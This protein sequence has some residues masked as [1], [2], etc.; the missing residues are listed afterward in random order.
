MPKE[1]LTGKAVRI[2][3][4][5]DDELM[6]PS[7]KR[8]ALSSGEPSSKP[9]EVA[10]TEDVLRKLLADQ[11]QQFL[12]AQSAALAE[13]ISGLEK[14][15]D[16]RMSGIEGK[17][18][19]HEERFRDLEK[20]LA[21]GLEASRSETSSTRAGSDSSDMEFRRKTTLVLGG[22]QRDTRRSVILSDVSSF[23]GKLGI[24]SSLVDN[25]AFTTGPRRNTA[26]L[27]FKIR[28]GEGLT[29]VRQRMLKVIQMTAK[30]EL[31]VSSSG[32]K[33]FAT[34][35]KTPAER[36]LGATCGLVRA[37]AKTFGEDV[38]DSLEVDYHTG[39]AWLGER[40][41][42]DSSSPKPDNGGPYHDLLGKYT[43]GWVDM[44]AF[45][46]EA[47]VSLSTVQDFFLKNSR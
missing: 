23:F 5:D 25:E 45:A 2:P 44:A 30:G 37:A 40:R 28:A 15:Q 35:S 29:A 6:S 31:T 36:E 17:L 34:Y 24:D 7:A 18:S 1:S 47:G 8:A 27:N 11:S 9:R 26:L 19:E 10:V 43:K 22:W 14:K 4:D 39:T 16:V 42:A 12:A 46:G 32:K 13:A 20:R 3:D 21:E 33:F 41:I 38:V